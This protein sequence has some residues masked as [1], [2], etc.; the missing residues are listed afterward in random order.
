MHKK[1]IEKALGQLDAE[2]ATYFGGVA[3]KLEED[4]RIENTAN[5]VYSVLKDVMLELPIYLEQKELIKLLIEFVHRNHNRIKIA[6]FD[7]SFVHDPSSIRDVTGE[8]VHQ[9]VK[10]SL[11]KHENGEIEEHMQSVHKLTWPYRDTDVA[12]PEDDPD[13]WSE[14]VAKSQQWLAE[15]GGVDRRQAGAARIDDLASEKAKE[16]KKLEKVTK[17]PELEKIKITDL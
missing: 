10:L 8:F 6:L 16:A 14:A 12:D 2:R 11:E 3:N 9:V 5:L 4:K 13:E 17:P 7:P 1:I 15:N